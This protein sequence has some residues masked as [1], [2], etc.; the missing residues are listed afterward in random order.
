[1]LHGL[2]H[3][4]CALQ[5]LQVDAGLRLPLGLHGLKVQHAVVVLGLPLSSSGLPLADADS[6]QQGDHLASCSDRLQHAAAPERLQQDSCGPEPCSIS[7]AAHPASMHGHEDTPAEAQHSNPRRTHRRAANLHHTQHGG[8]LNGMAALNGHASS[9]QAAAGA[10]A[11]ASS[12]HSPSAHVRPLHLHHLQQ[13][14]QQHSSQPHSTDAA[15]ASTINGWGPGM[16]WFEGHLNGFSTHAPATSQHEPL[17]ALQGAATQ[18]HNAAAALMQLA[19]AA[20]Q[21]RGRPDGAH[22][23]L[24]MYL[25]QQQQLWHPDLQQPGPDDQATVL[26]G[27]WERVAALASHLLSASGL[28][29]SMPRGMSPRQMAGLLWACGSL[30][31][32]LAPHLQAPPGPSGARPPHPVLR[33]LKR[34]GHALALQLEPRLADCPPQGLANAL[35]ALAHMR[36]RPA[37]DWLSAFMWTTGKLLHA[38]LQTG[39]GGSQP[40]LQSQQQQQ[41]GEGHAPGQTQGQGVMQGHR[42][43]HWERRVGAQG[44]PMSGFKAQ[45]LSSMLWALATLHVPPSCVWWAAFQGVCV[46]QLQ[47]RAFGQQGLANLMWGMAKLQLRPDAKFMDSWWVVVVVWVGRSGGQ[48]AGE[49][50]GLV[51]QQMLLV[52]SWLCGL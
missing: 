42:Q 27:S 40:K 50:G 14:Q 17:G 20:A 4:V 47:A 41:W 5:L 3:D 48:I 23:V 16:L 37:S 28:S 51:I 39:G 22:T 18:P 49:L 11:H 7:H 32:S 1:M 26:T 31:T 29:G 13:E 25:K 19:C 15:H 2:R 10:D 35:W 34:S 44:Q 38:Q 30:H 12:L 52:K 21:A 24:S 33:Q 36:M 6:G 46:Q 43:E 8:R 9:P 45:E